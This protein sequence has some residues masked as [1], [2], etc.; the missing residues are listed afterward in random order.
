MKPQNL[1]RIKTERNIRYRPMKKLKDNDFRIGTWNVLTMLQAGK[2]A[3]ITD[4]LISYGI[5]IAALQEIRW[6]DEG[7]LR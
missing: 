4:E 5:K 7:E 6:K 1:S 2:L 3:E